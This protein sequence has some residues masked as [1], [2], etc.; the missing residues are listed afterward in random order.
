MIIT[1]RLRS[2]YFCRIRKMVVLL[3]IKVAVTIYSV[4]KY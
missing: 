4:L 2:R 3:V 1:G